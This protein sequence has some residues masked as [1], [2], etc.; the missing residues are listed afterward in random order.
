M[1]S[2]YIVP[3]LESTRFW[4]WFS[5]VSLFLSDCIFIGVT[6]GEN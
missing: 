1:L 5:G 4:L 6:Q 3:F 2:L